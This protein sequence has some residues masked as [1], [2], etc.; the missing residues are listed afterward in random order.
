MDDDKE[1]EK[2]PPIKK[3]KLTNQTNLDVS[4]KQME[5]NPMKLVKQKGGNFVA[6]EVI[7]SYLDKILK[8]C[9]SKEEREALIKDHPRPDL[10]SCKVS[11]I[12]KYIKEFLGKIS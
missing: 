2:E 1:N 10:P 6:P 4:T 8:Q 9:L 3:Q 12:D 7:T 11:V 5:F